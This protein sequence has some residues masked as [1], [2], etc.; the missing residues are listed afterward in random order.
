MQSC[1]FGT[2]TVTDE[3]GNTHT[4]TYRL[5]TQQIPAGQFFFEDYGVRVDD[6]GGESLCLPSLTHSRTQIHALLT[7]LLEYGVSPISLY[8]VAEDWAKENHL[9]QPRLQQVADVG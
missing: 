9:P 6:S 3:L 8:D 4:F 2:K 7:Q 5:I 1:I